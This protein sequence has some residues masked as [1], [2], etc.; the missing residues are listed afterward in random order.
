MTAGAIRTDFILSAEI[1][2]I[3]LNEVADQ[4]FWPRFI[5]LVVVA[6]VITAAVYG[7]V[8]LIVKMDDIGL[9]LAQRTSTVR[10]EIGRG[11]V[12][13]M[14]KL[15]SA[16][17]TIGTVAM[18]WVGGHILLVGTDTLGW[19]GR[20]ALSTTPRNSSITPSRASAGYWPGWST[21][22]RRQWSA[23]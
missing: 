16:L 11:L 1:M 19:H 4:S 15:L 2:V 3:A 21:L 9:S 8:A 7:V 5:I 12:A 20:T 13:A 18:L 22:R 17:S 14:P 6:F 10:A 23:W